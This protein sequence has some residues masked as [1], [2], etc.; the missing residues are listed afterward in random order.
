MS[1]SDAFTTGG[2]W[3][4]PDRGDG[5]GRPTGT[6][7]TTRITLLRSAV[8]MH[9]CCPGLTLVDCEFGHDLGEVPVQ[10]LFGEVLALHGFTVFAEFA[11]GRRHGDGGVM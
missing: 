4:V 1:K 2:A 3:G 10:F 7:T 9:L 6:G 11:V 5:D 8:A